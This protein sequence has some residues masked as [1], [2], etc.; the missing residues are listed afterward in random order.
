MVGM[1]NWK[2]Y[3]FKFFILWYICGVVF[4]GFNLLPPWL[5]WSNSVFILLSGLLS[6]IYFSEV[7]G[8]M[9]GT[10]IAIII[11]MTTFIIEYFG[12][13]T[14]F[15]FGHYTY[16]NQFAPNLFG[17]PIA[18]GFAWVMVIATGYAINEQLRIQHPISRAFFGGLTALVMDLVL[19]PVAYKAKSYWIW[20]EGGDYYDI[21][22]TN[23][24]GWFIVAFLIHIVLLAVKQRTIPVLWQRRLIALYLL[25][26]SMFV[27]IAYQNKLYAAVGVGIIGGILLVLFMKYREM[28]GFSRK[29]KGEF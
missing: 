20:H 28:R 25:I 7:L 15:L 14:T 27:F 12:A 29:I 24:C 17:V 4:V 1:N 26:L 21:P 2:H 19:D 3:I 9:R 23:F 6:W 22:W 18:I 5:E 8:Q 16:T 10:M 13:S 11:C